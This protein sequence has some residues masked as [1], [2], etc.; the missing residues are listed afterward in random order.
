MLSTASL[1]IDR[2]SLS[3]FLPDLRSIKAFEALQEAVS[4]TIPDAVNSNTSAIDDLSNDLGPSATA[5][6]AALL[7]AAIALSL[8]QEAQGMALQSQVSALLSEVAELRNQINDLR[9][10]YVL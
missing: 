4:Q 6:V 2:D 10:G 8:G 1:Q 3:S 5:G 9:Q 7:E